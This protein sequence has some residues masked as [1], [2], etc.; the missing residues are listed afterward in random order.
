MVM[1]ILSSVVTVGAVGTANI[2]FLIVFISQVVSDMV[3]KVEGMKVSTRNTTHQM[4]SLLVSVDN[5][6]GTMS[7]SKITPRDEWKDWI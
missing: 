3:K 1:D 2:L 4:H 7:T 6:D 5:G